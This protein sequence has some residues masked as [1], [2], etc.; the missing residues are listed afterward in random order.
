MG[1]FV[2]V[3]A[4]DG[5]GGGGGDGADQ[6]LFMDLVLLVMS[7]KINELDAFFCHSLGERILR[8]MSHG[9]FKRFLGQDVQSSS[10]CFSQGLFLSGNPMAQDDVFQPEY[11]GLKVGEF[12]SYFVWWK[13]VSYTIYDTCK[14][15]RK[16]KY[17]TH[18]PTKLREPW[19]FFTTYITILCLVNY[20]QA[21]T[22]IL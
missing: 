6:K 7:N 9:H 14:L 8:V 20:F 13:E 18:C 22:I 16:S 5:G 4:A 19:L 3:A 10:E 17:Y 15:S 12:N 2:V 11:W 21:Y 1:F